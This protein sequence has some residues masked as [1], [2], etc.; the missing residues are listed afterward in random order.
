MFLNTEWNY[1]TMVNFTYIR[2][3]Y[4][5]KSFIN[6]NKKYRLYK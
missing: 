6:G 5:I 1:K 3:I 2:K 4:S